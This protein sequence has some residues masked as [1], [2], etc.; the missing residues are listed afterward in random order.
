MCN[1]CVYAIKLTPQYHQQHMQES[2]KKI[3]ASGETILMTLNKK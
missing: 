1:K 2:I 3:I